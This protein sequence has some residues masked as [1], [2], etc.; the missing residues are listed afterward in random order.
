MNLS[1]YRIFALFFAFYSNDSLQ[2]LGNDRSFLLLPFFLSLK[3]STSYSS[4][5]DD[6]VKPV[7]FS[8]LFISFTLFDNDLLYGL[9]LI[10]QW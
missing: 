9:F 1:Q 7:I 8:V 6:C 5:S 2:M 4:R 10:S 3:Y